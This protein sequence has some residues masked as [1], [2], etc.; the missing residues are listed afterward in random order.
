MKSIK[1][2][3]I[4]FVLL[5]GVTSFAAGV[6][7][8]QCNTLFNTQNALKEIDISSE[9]IQSF[10]H[11]S[12]TIEE[13]EKKKKFYLDEPI[14]RGDVAAAKLTLQEAISYLVKPKQALLG[15]GLVEQSSGYEILFLKY[16]QRLK[17]F[18]NFI[19]FFNAHILGTGAKYWNSF[20]MS[21]S[22]NNW[23]PKTFANPYMLNNFETPPKYGYGLFVKTLRPKHS[24]DS[25][26]MSDKYGTEFVAQESEISVPIAVDPE[27][28]SEI[29]FWEY[30]QFVNTDKTIYYGTQNSNKSIRILKTG[31]NHYTLY[32]GLS[33]WDAVNIDYVQNL[34][35]KAKYELEINPDGSYQLIKVKL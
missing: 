20:L 11:R 33:Y 25:E 28:I 24:L 1:Q 12:T 6:H 26:V 15:N 19:K 16:V 17:N 34:D 32:E 35:V 3:F 7:G 30:T 21:W 31:L 9:F 27:M 4:L 22:T 10:N 29:T 13:Y 8:G 5:K 2:T 18:P 23:T 14:Y